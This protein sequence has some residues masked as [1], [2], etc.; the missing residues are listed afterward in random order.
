MFAS[1]NSNVRSHVL[2]ATARI[3]V[4]SSSGRT[5]GVRAL[6]DQGSEMT[7]IT[8]RLAQ[9]LKLKRLKMPI[10]IN[11]IGGIN[12]GTFRSTANIKIAPRDSSH[13]ELTA[14]ALILKTLTS[15]SPKRIET[16]FAWSHLSDITWTGNDP[17]SSEFIDILI[18]ADIYAEVILDGIRKSKVGHPIA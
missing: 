7:F 11:A 15:Y 6:P 13:P 17:T 4:S 9:C 16:N 3:T 12:A 1:S 14:T 18:G 2:L 8:E 5:V 10:S